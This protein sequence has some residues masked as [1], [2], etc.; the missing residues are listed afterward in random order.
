MAQKTATAATENTGPR[1]PCPEDA[2]CRRDGAFV[3]WV[4][5]QV[6]YSLLKP[7]EC[8][9]GILAGNIKVTWEL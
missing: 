2:A 5:R 4:K 3:L 7:L 6:D 8:R 1:E 9:E